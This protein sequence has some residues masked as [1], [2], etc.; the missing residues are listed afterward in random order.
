MNSAS[1]IMTGL[2]IIADCID[3]RNPSK[4]GFVLGGSIDD[5][6]LAAMY[7][8]HHKTYPEKDEHKT[9]PIA[10]NGLEGVKNHIRLTIEGLFRAETQYNQQMRQAALEQLRADLKKSHQPHAQGTVAEIAAKFG[11]SKSEVR[12]RKAD[13]TLDA[14]FEQATNT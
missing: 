11:I 13:G 9:C 8:C 6:I 2:S 5:E 12:R 4:I 7:F 10:N 14:L 1:K 3:L